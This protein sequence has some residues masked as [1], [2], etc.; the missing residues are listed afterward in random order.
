MRLMGCALLVG[1]L[2][3]PNFAWAQVPEVRLNFEGCSLD[4]W[5]PIE[6][7]TKLTTGD[8]PVSVA[9]YIDVGMDV[10]CQPSDLVLTED[11]LCGYAWSVANSSSPRA[12]LKQCFF[13]EHNP[14]SSA[15][16]LMESSAAGECLQTL[17]V[18]SADGHSQMGI[19]TTVAC[20]EFPDPAELIAYGLAMVDR[21][22]ARDAE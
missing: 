13:R 7:D 15:V 19:Q 1:S 9:S 4:Y 20:S 10:S 18:L 3:A 12:D 21:V 2:L 14:Y 6:P 22:S 16:S 5:M 11:A 17:Y 8:P